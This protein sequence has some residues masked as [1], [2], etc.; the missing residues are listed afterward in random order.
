MSR[1]ERATLTNCCMIYDGTRVL[2][3]NRTD[4]D[5]PGI[6]FPGGHVEPGESLTDAVIR[7]VYEETGLTIRAPRLCG[8]K[9]WL[10]DDGSRYIILLYKTDRFEGTLHAS[11]EGEVFWVELDEMKKMNLAD[12]METQLEV[13]LNEDISE[14]F[15]FR[16]HG[17][18]V[19]VLK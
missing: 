1:M 17:K 2:V 6:T 14:E 11:D 5:W 18:W 3:Q 8:V 12:T 9:D 10:E 4:P 19:S 13:F 16:E 7:E 15:Y